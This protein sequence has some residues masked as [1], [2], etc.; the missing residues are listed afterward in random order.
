MGDAADHMEDVATGRYFFPKLERTL[1][2][3]ALIEAV[4]QFEWKPKSG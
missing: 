2:E 4:A 3:M 1:N